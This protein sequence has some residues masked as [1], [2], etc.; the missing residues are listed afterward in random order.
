LPGM[1]VEHLQILGY[2]EGSA[3]NTQYSYIVEVRELREKLKQAML[4]PYRALCTR[5]S[6]RRGT[7]ITAF[8]HCLR[9]LIFTQKV[10]FDILFVEFMQRVCDMSLSSLPKLYKGQATG[11]SCPV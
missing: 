1:Q 8:S 4:N 11:G 5:A 10:L 3:G 6:G 9:E 7:D 2:F